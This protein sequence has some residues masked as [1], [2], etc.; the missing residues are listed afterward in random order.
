LGNAADIVVVYE[1]AGHLVDY[2]VG[3]TIIIEIYESWLGAEE[4]AREW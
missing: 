3:Q 4:S 2:Q 1:F